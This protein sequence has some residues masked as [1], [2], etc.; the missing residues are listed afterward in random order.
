MGEGS[1]REMRPEDSGSEAGGAGDDTPGA[2][3]P[4]TSQNRVPG[5]ISAWQFMHQTCPLPADA[6]GSLLETNGEVAGAAIG[7]P[8]S[9]QNRL[10]GLIAAL[11]FAHRMAVR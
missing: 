8:H 3:V 9:S 7:E 4:H 1:I 2:G 11:Q 5:V 10:P 6:G